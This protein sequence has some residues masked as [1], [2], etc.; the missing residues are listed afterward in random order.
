MLGAICNVRQIGCDSQGMPRGKVA[1][2]VVT[3][4]LA[5]PLA[6]V[7]VEIRPSAALPTSMA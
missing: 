1:L 5:D 3:H 4:R 7:L 2:A 6:G